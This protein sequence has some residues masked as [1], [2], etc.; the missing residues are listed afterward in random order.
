MKIRNHGWSNSLLGIS[1]GVV[2]NFVTSMGAYAEVKALLVGLVGRFSISV[3][4]DFAMLFLC[5]FSWR[6]Q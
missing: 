2:I 6:T 1:V 5:K 4:H 3:K